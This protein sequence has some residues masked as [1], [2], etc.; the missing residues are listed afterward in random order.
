LFLCF[1]PGADLDRCGGPDGPT[2][3]D[4]ELVGG[5]RDQRTRRHGAAIDE[6]DRWHLAT[7]QRIANGPGGV[8]TTTDVKASV[9]P[10]TE[11]FSFPS[12]PVGSRAGLG[13]GSSLEKIEIA[14]FLDLKD[15]FD[16]CWAR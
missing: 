7:E 11:S 4:D 1:T 3:G 6:R 5:Q 8:H 2:V 12:V 16:V 13:F 15:V 9:L 10:L 14:T